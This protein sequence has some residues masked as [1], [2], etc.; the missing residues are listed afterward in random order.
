MMNG[1]L[2][3]TTVMRN[4]LPLIAAA[5]AVV[6]LPAAT[7]PARPPITTIANFVVMSDNIEE[8]RKFFQ[9]KRVIAGA[10]GISVLKVNDHQYIEL[11]PTLANPSDDKLIQI[12]YETTDALKLRDYLA[13]KGFGVP[14]QVAKDSGGNYALS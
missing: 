5:F 12:G 13:S 4:F 8:A 14:A 3:E 2:R 6:M 9:Q 10:A 7:A 1:R 11:A